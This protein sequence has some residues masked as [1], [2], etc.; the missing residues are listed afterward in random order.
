MG[1]YMKKSKIRGDVAVKDASQSSLG[2]RTRAKA[3]ALQRLQSSAESLP[4]K[5]E[6]CYLELRSRRLEKPTLVRQNMQKIPS[7]RD[8]LNCPEKEEFGS[9]SV[10]KE[11]ESVCRAF[12]AGDLEIDASFGENNLESEARGRRTRESTPCSLIGATDTIITPGSSTKS[13]TLA[14]TNQRV[15]NT[16]IRSMPTDHELEEFFSQMEEAQHRHFIDK[17]NFDIVND[18]PLPGRYIWEKLSP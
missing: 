2:V 4:P 12:E 5:P 17:Y 11:E 6:Q 1:K 8:S 14:P 9:G 18:L 10:P 7:P 13:A 15:R 16:R 3:L